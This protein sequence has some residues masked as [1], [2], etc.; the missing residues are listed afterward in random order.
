M[1]S[2]GSISTFVNRARFS[3]LGI[4]AIV[5]ALSA[6]AVWAV[7]AL[8]RA[9][10]EARASAIV[11]DLRA[12][13][14]AFQAYAHAHGDW[15]SADASPGNVPAGM[16]ARLRETNWT[17]PTPIGGHYTWKVGTLHRGRRYAAAIVIVSTD[18]NA[19]TEDRAQLQEIDR[20][21]DDGNF[22][23]GNFR[24]GFRHQLLFVLEH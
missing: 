2:A 20:Q 5:L 19:T 11:H 16:T 24:L 8:Q 14:Q 13:A 4:S 10:R 12:F 22:A 21:I 23:T 1:N 18:R 15:P 3:S 6:I 9:R 17:R 7:P